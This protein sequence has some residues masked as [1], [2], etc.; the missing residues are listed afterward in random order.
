MNWIKE[1]IIRY[2]LC[3]V[4][5]FGCK[6]NHTNIQHSR[7]AR[8]SPSLAS[9]VCLPVPHNLNDKLII[10]YNTQATFWMHS[11]QKRDF[12]LADGEHCDTD[13]STHTHTPTLL[14]QY[15]IRRSKGHTPGMRNC[16]ASREFV[17]FAA[18]GHDS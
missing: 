9:C 18:R 15:I 3:V 11:T 1:R 17:C 4:P 13:N 10:I 8:N 2:M 7:N 6:T 5:T 14:L 12:C 16:V